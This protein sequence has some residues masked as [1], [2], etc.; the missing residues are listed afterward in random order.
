M[1]YLSKERH[2]ELAAELRYLIEE[3]YPK[4][5]EDVAE[6]GSQGDRSDNAGYREAR[7]IQ[8]KT[9]SRIKFL[10][11]ILENSRVIDPEFLPKDT[12][13]LLSRVEFTNLATKTRMKF[14]IV[15]PHEMDLEA[16]KISLN[17]PIGAAL[18]GKKV[19]EIAEAKIPAGTLSLKIESIEI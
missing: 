9:I 5:A 4:V 8:G 15:S 13:T 7:R 10:Q 3:V 6:T 18:M 11:K 19:G 1:E 14:Q 16:G 17:S 12:V 2:N